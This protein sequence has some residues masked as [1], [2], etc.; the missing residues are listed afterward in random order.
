MVNQEF[1]HTA[2]IC[3]KCKKAQFI[4]LSGGK[5]VANQKECVYCGR[6]KDE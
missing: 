5:E 3:R 6:R 1:T 4:L 2:R